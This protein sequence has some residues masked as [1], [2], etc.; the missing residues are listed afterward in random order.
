V[1]N[2]TVSMFAPL[3]SG[4]QPHT[5]PIPTEQLDDLG[6]MLVLDQYVTLLP[7]D[8]SDQ[9]SVRVIQLNEHTLDND[10]RG[11]VEKG[12]PVHAEHVGARELEG[13]TS[14]VVFHAVSPVIVVEVVAQAV[15]HAGQI[16]R[17]SPV[18]ERL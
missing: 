3:R 13:D 9:R 6:P 16:L 1:V 11:T 17:C 4:S 7:G 18:T 8:G 15:Q 2:V 12:P 5:E 14:A 10:P